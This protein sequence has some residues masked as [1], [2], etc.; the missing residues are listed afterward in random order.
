MKP[1]YFSCMAKFSKTL[2]NSATIKM[3]FFAIIGNRKK[4]Q[5]TSAN[6]QQGAWICP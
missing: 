1:D 5:R 2:K 6:M 3:E 4:L